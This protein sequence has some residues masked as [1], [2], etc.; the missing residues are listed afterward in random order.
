M[1]DV[2]AVMKSVVRLL[3]LCVVGL[4]YA[5]PDVWMVGYAKKTVQR[6]RIHGFARTAVEVA[7]GVRNAVAWLAEQWFDSIG[8]IDT[9][10]RV[11]L[12]SADGPPEANPLYLDYQPTPVR[13]MRA[14]L[15]QLDADMGASTFV[16]F[17]S[18]KGRV[19]LI[20]SEFSFTRVMGVE[21]DEKL[22][23]TACRNISAFRG[24]R[25]CQDVSSVLGRAEEFAVPSGDLVL[26]FFHSFEAAI[27][28]RILHNV[29]RSYRENPRRILLLLFRPSHAHLVER[30][31]EFRRLPVQPLPYDVVRLSSDYR[32]VTGAPYDA[33]VFVAG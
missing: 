11:L 8:G 27:M 19:L 23:R 7:T 16:D 3:S 29:V 33:A 18:G 26:Y 1:T 24:R 21:F 4:W 32:D 9:A 22:H 17:G 31:P 6:I 25:Q 15:R 2:Q 5:R 13:T 28:E 14:L 10:G 20:A 30:C 12:Y